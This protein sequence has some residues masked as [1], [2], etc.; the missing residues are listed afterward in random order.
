MTNAHETFRQAFVAAADAAL[1]NVKNR[2]EAAV[3]KNSALE[4]FACAAVNET[5]PRTEANE[6]LAR[7]L[8]RA[9]KAV[10]MGGELPYYIAK[11]TALALEQAQPGEALLPTDIGERVG[12]HQEAEFLW[13]VADAWKKLPS[14]EQNAHDTQRIALMKEAYRKG[15]DYEQTCRGCAQCAVAAISDVTGK[16]DLSMFRAANG[17]AAG[18]GLLGDGVCGGYAGGTLSIGLYAGR[19]KEFFGGDKAEKDLNGKLVRALHGRFI[20]TYGSVICHDIHHVIFGRAFHITR[21]DDKEAFEL[22]G[23]HTCDKCPAVVG[24]AAAW[25]VEILYDAGLLAL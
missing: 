13:L 6:A 1:A 5:T 7:T 23:A 16:E 24:M 18:M 9:A 2:E 10:R 15:Y 11:L 3:L 8:A 25:T 14:F 17:F 12:M 21:Q 20:E 19:R 22:A 4:E